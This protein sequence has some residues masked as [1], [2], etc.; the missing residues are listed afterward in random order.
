MNISP[1]TILIILMSAIFFPFEIMFIKMLGEAI[2]YSQ[3]QNLV[4]L[5]LGIPIF[6]A[7]YIAELKF[8]DIINY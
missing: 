4:A 8:L 3:A 5:T 6:L 7:V 2:L 1:K